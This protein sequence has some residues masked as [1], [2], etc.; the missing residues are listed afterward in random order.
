MAHCD[1]AGMNGG[2]RIISH[3][4]PPWRLMPNGWLGN[5]ALVSLPVLTEASSWMAPGGLFCRRAVE[6][7]AIEAEASGC[8]TLR[9]NG[10]GCRPGRGL[11]KVARC[12]KMRTLFE[13]CASWKTPK[14]PSKDAHPFPRMRTKNCAPSRGARVAGV[15]HSAPFTRGSQGHCRHRGYLDFSAGSANGPDRGRHRHVRIG[16]GAG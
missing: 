10:T 2:N 6:N 3:G 11:P 16:C 5:P 14:I 15:L 13:K 12:S 7:N 9:V 1:A 4:A 8:A